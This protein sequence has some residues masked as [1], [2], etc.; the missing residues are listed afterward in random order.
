MRGGDGGEMD[1][2]VEKSQKKRQ[3]Q[4]WKISVICYMHVGASPTS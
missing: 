4:V 3:G 1:H 2:W